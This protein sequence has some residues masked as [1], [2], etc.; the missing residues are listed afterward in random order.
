MCGI[1]GVIGT[2][3]VGVMQRMLT[4]IAHRGPDGQ[5]IESFH[6]PERGTP[7]VLGHCRLAVIDLS[8][9]GHQPMSNEDGTI[10]VSYNGEIYNFL[11]I[12]KELEEAGHVFESDTD[13]EVLVHA[14]E[15]WGS[16]MIECLNGMYAFGIWDANKKE[17]LLARDRLGIKPLYYCRV[18]REFA[19]ASEI[20]ALLELPGIQRE[21]CMEAL[22]GYL[23][24]GYVPG[25]LTMFEGI[26]KLDPGHLLS[27]K[28][29][30]VA[31]HRYWSIPY[32]RWLEGDLVTHVRQFHDLLEDAVSLRTISDV[33]LGTFLSGGIDS[34]VITALVAQCSGV[35]KQLESYCVGYA[36]ETSRHNEQHYANI[37]ASSLGITC[38]TALCTPSYA[39]DV[40]PRLIWHL[41]EPV[42]ED[43]LPPYALLCQQARKS[44]TV[45]L[46]G[47][48]A[49]E[50]LFG[51]R[52]YVLENL[53]SRIDRMPTMFRSALR[54]A[55]RKV[56]S[57]DRLKARAL[58]CALSPTSLDSFFEWRAFHDHRERLELYGPKIRSRMS[59]L[60]TAHRLFDTLDSTGDSGAGSA[61]VMDARYRMVDYILSRT[62]KLSMSVALEVRTPFLDHRLIEFM[63]AVPPRHKFSKGHGKYL[64]REAT[65]DLLPPPIRRR[66]KKPFAAPTLAWMGPLWDKYLQSSTLVADGLI[67]IRAL[68]M[69]AKRVSDGGGS[70]EKSWAVLTLE[71]WYRMFIRQENEI[72]SAAKNFRVATK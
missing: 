34:S 56:S 57:R 22:A 72:L 54:S 25:P 40:M 49:D 63:V 15:Q 30:E 24:L 68:Q 70:I 12:R 3:D 58:L 46:S 33:P 36:D 47:E 53:R 5:G 18:G 69:A 65:V 44:L 23:E 8:K 11:A 29:G 31:V 67:D 9:R 14:Y 2:S 50:F 45:V 20:K 1:A 37:T 26:K 52:Y 10:W 39:Y 66:R 17:L 38:H 27:L 16:E 64:L 48:G 19:F 35:R 62:D 28:G 4:V 7:A 61:P 32:G 71:M 42:A 13:T 43:L 55:V 59:E 41:D 21:V 60:D 6:A 51:Y